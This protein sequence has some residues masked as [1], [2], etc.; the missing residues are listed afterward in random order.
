MSNAN[1][2]KELFK[3]FSAGDDES[4]EVAARKIVNLERAKKHHV[5]ASDLE[6]FLNSANEKT[7]NLLESQPLPIKGVPKDSEGSVDL[8]EVVRP[9]LAKKDV[10]YSEIN[11]SIL[12]DFIAEQESH[13]LLRANSLRAN[14]KLL[15]C[16]PPGCGK[17][18][19]AE[20][21]AFEL[22]LPL[23]T[24]RID[25]VV[26]SFLGET[27]SNLR[28]IFEFIKS[29]RVVAFFDE[30]DA[31]AKERSNRDEHGELK[32]V[33]NSFLQLMDSYSG[34]SVI[35]AATNHEGDLDKA[36]W[37]RFDEILKF[38]NPAIEQIKELLK[39]KLKNFLHDVP[40]GSKEFLLQFDGFSHADVERIVFASAKKAL[41]SNSPKI[42]KSIIDEVVY[43]EFKRKDFVKDIVRAGEG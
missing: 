20:M 8:V 37:R 19:T 38:E 7:G 18:I 28:K 29:Y 23:V 12:S 3:S 13:N 14:S 36:L 16:G 4:F 15:L 30:F 32:R 33:V 35:V 5:L 1:L 2:L 25:S 24:V 17:S 26:S 41:L 10:V 6:K 27:A 39:I 40:I 31:L 22:N 11:N 42:T 9:R 43:K 34:H 21:L